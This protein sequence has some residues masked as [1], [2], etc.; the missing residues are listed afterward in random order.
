MRRVLLLAFIVSLM[1]AA[2]VSATVRTWDGGGIDDNWRTAENWV[3]DIAPVSGDDLVFPAV[4]AKYTSSNNLTLFSTVRTMTFEGG[5]YTISGSPLPVTAGITIVD[6]NQAINLV[7]SLSANQTFT[8]TNAT[9]VGVVGAVIMG[10]RSLT[11]DGAGGIGI[12]LVSGTGQFIKNGSGGALISTAS[13]YSGPV[14][15]NGGFL[16]IDASIPSS[17]VTVDIPAGPTTFD[18]RLFGLTDRRANYFAAGDGLGVTGGLG[19]TGTVGTVSVLNGG[20]S[21]G[22]LTAPTGILNTGNLT[23]SAGA[24]FVPKLNGDTVGTNGYDQVN[25]TGS[26]SISGAVINVLPSAA[27]PP[28]LRLPLVVLRN[29]GS[30]PIAGEFANAPEGSYVYDAGHTTRF[31]ISYHGGDGNDVILIRS[32]MR[33]S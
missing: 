21:A 4:A 8:A 33:G 12:G 18:T 20:I 25:V 3:G 5:A 17:S 11:I 1:C 28:R 16:I 32:A 31:R 19:G 7:L 9:A 15:E 14:R 6:G 23:L 10:A 22:T 29:D 30:D 26:V 13:S 2:S 27:T 24:S